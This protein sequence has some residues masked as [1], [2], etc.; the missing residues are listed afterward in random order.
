V[1][2]FTVLVMHSPN[3]TH[4]SVA[5]HMIVDEPNWCQSLPSSDGVYTLV[6]IVSLCPSFPFIRCIMLPVRHA[7]YASV[8]RL[9]RRTDFLQGNDHKRSPLPPVTF[10]LGPRRPRN[11]SPH[12]RQ[13][14]QLF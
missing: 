10:P 8:A 1:F 3:T 11:S 6:S 14:V 2:R 4:T 9:P 5:V 12:L 7:V 13:H